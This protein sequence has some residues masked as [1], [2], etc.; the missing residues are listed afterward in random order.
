MKI[1]VICDTH[2]GVRNDSLIILNN[3]EKFYDNVF[4][5]KLKEFGITEVLHLGDVFD[6]RK[7]INFLTLNKTKKMFFTKLRDEKINMSIIAGN[8]DVFYKNVNDINS[9]KELLQEFDNINIYYEKP[10][11]ITYDGLPILLAPWICAANMVESMKT[12]KT[13]T[14]QILM[15]HF[16]FQ[17]FEMMKGQLCDHGLDKNLFKKF[18]HI[19]TGHF[20][21][22]STHDNITYLGAPYEMTWTDYA[23]KR[24]F[25]IFDTETREMTWIE[26]PYTIFK[27]ID[28]DDTNLT[29]E[30]LND[31]DTSLLTSTYIKVIIKNK[32]NPYM[33]DL[34]LDKIQASQPADLKIVEDSLDFEFF[35]E[36]DLLDEAQDTLSLLRNYVQGLDIKV[37]KGQ[38]ERYLTTLYH[39]ANGL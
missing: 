19:Y 23:G 39:E 17:G 15:G 11:E 28:Y 22:P 7:Y 18:D 8:H 5:P 4:F 27:K 25:H 1:A 24:G 21:H 20:H 26:N 30:E 6:R 9:L 10:V 36:E 16:E 14:A 35:S 38:V 3:F 13:S 37:D 2:F 32:N 33:F 29:I 12:F 31:L 34:F